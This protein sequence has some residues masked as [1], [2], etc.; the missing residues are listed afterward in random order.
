[1]LR[2]ASQRAITNTFYDTGNYT[3]IYQKFN[4][5]SGTILSSASTGDILLKSL[6]SNS[7]GA[8]KPEE[9]T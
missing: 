2:R 1:M 7:C 9:Q 4:R 3:P 5:C 8:C 6:L